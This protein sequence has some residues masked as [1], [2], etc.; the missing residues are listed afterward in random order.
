MYA[1]IFKISKHIKIFASNQIYAH[2]LK[3]LRI[4]QNICL[5]QNIR[6]FKI[7]APL[8]YLRI[9]K[10]YAP[11]QECSRLVI[12]DSNKAAV[13][14]FAAYERCMRPRM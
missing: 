9:Y 4:P 7:F 11:Q 5:H 3:Y 12:Y 10:I 14:I 13:E 1:H 2:I 8:K 6:S